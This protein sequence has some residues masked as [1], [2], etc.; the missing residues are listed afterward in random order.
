MSKFLLVGLGNIGAEYE[1][2]RHNIGFDVADAFARKH[3]AS[4]S[5]ERLAQVA[6]A[7]LK[8]KMVICI[9]PATYMN[10]SGKAVKYWMDK[11]NVPLENVLVVVDELALPL[12]K[13]RL[14]PGG[15]AAGHNGLKSIEEVLQTEMY[16]RLRFGIG[17][18]YPKG[19]QVDYVLGKWR[20][21]ELPLVQLKIGKSVELAETFVA[22]G[23]ERA[24]N[25]YN[26]LNFSL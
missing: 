7:K 14:R 11:E 21:E 10:L 23:I 13:L 22:T 19:A 9:K 15:S 18:D 2:T 6:R 26:K 20:A 8:G 4:F 24:M 25:L 3:E 17:N 5:T 12:S 1:G 16:P